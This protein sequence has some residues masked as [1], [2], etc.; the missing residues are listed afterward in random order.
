MITI[1]G[2][3]FLAQVSLWSVKIA[4][5]SVDGQEKDRIFLFF[6]V[7]CAVFNL[8]ANTVFFFFLISRFG[9]KKSIIA[10]LIL[11]SFG[12]FASVLIASED[13][14][15]KGK[16]IQSCIIPESLFPEMPL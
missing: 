7:P 4:F 1:L 10:S 11:A 9:R 13:N 2:H 15:S 16:K 8:N 5:W 3:P 6:A 14:T 12:A